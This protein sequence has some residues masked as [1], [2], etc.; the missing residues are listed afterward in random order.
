M[1]SF[2]KKIET[3]PSEDI[4]NILTINFFKNL[5]NLDDKQFW[6]IDEKIVEIIDSAVIHFTIEELM[7]K[8]NKLGIKKE[9]NLHIYLDGIPSFMKLQSQ[10]N[11]ARENVADFLDAYDLSIKGKTYFKDNLKKFEY[12]NTKK[13]RSD[14]QFMKKIE[15]ILNLIKKKKILNIITLKTCNKSAE[16]EISMLYDINKLNNGNVYVISNDADVILMTMRICSLKQNLNIYVYNEIVYDIR[17]LNKKIYKQI[18]EDDNIQKDENGNLHIHNFSLLCIALFGTDFSSRIFRPT[19]FSINYII[20]KIKEK[21]G[22]YIEND[23]TKINFI[24]LLNTISNLKITDCRNN[25]TV[26]KLKENIEVQFV[27][28]DKRTLNKGTLINLEWDSAARAYKYY[29]KKYDENREYI[30]CLD[31]KILGNNIYT[32]TNVNAMIVD[33]HTIYKRESEDLEVLQEYMKSLE[34]ANKFFSLNE[35]D[36]IENDKFIK[37]TSDN[38]LDY[39]IIKQFLDDKNSYIYIQIT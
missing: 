39:S 30:Q 2:K 11:N 9:D 12:F 14:T 16:A 19:K 10:R 6:K 35:N 1:A 38:F 24:N 15:E 20:N 13:I 36:Y 33:P 25:L 21:N 23:F 37:N 27:G 22:N 29:I 31:R 8:L 26:V 32:Q 28:S 7:M 4:N 34:Y 3:N 18:T 5:S 17:H